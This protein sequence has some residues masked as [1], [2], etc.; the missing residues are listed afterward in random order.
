MLARSGISG[1]KWYALVDAKCHNESEMRVAKTIASLKFVC[2][3]VHGSP[4]Q[5]RL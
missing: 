2:P 4:A 3:E 5:T 1:P